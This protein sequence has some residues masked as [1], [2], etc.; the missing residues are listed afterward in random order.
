MSTEVSQD[1]RSSSE[2]RLVLLGL[3]EAQDTPRV[4]T[5]QDVA[6]LLRQ[7]R[8]RATAA[9][10]HSAIEGLTHAGALQKVSRGLF[11]NRRARPAVEAMEAAAHI[12]A[13][14]LVSLETVLGEC[15]FLN[16]PAALV[17]AVLPQR[18][19]QFPRVGQLT[20][21]AGLVFRFH[22]LAP[23]FFADSPDEERLMLQAGRY[24]AV[25]KPEVAALH[26]LH[27]WKS[28]R[29]PMRKPPQDVDFGVLDPELLDHLASR[30]EL[31][32]ALQAWKNDVSATG[33]IQEP[34]PPE[35]K[36]TAQ[37]RQRAH[38]ARTRLLARGQSRG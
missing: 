4:C 15:G 36:V 35:G 2:W 11:L 20:T 7:V 14:A 6:R 23:R 13:G 33:D 19:G 3:L 9:T 5:T 37:Q 29:S 8:P 17:T 12:R 26:W 32:A 25:A 21:S 16:N 31:S 34:S 24:C 38:D 10:L 22:A 28:P 18:P 1:R 27:L 30:W